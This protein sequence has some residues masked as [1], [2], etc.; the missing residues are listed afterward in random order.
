MK[1]NDEEQAMLAHPL[2]GRVVKVIALVDVPEPRGHVRSHRIQVGNVAIPGFVPQPFL[3]V[4]LCIVL[5]DSQG[6]QRG[7]K[8]LHRFLLALRR[9]VS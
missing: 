3:F 6:E 9:D 7:G 5:R 8:V 2:D 4:E 1:L